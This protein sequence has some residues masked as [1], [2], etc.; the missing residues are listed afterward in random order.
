MA[1]PLRWWLPASTAAAFALT[2]VLVWA[3]W[4]AKGSAQGEEEISEL[5][6]RLE[7]RIHDAGDEVLGAAVDLLPSAQIDPDAEPEGEVWSAVGG[8]EDEEVVEEALR[9]ATAILSPTPREG[10]PDPGGLVEGL[11]ASQVEK[12]LK[13]IGPVE[14]PRVVRRS[15]VRTG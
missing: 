12:L 11:N 15:E 2:I 10:L 4:R 13:E 8:A 6:S 3:P 7:S 14:R 9:S 1:S 5:R